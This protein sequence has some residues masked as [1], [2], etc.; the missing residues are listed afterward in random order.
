[1]S[2]V[3]AGVAAIEGSN[4]LLASGLGSITQ[5]YDADLAALAGSGV[6]WHR[7]AHGQQYLGT[8][9]YN[10]NRQRDHCD[11]RRRCGGQPDPVAP[12]GP[13]LHRKDGNGRHLFLTDGD[14][15]PARSDQPQDAATKNYVDVVAQGLDQKPTARLATAAALPTNTYVAGV[16]TI[17]ATGVLTVDGQTVALNDIV[18]VKDEAAALKNGLY[19]CTT[20]GAIGVAA[21][22][23]RHTSMDSSTEF[24]GAFIPVDSEGTTNANSLWLNTNATDPTVGTTAIT[25]VQLNKG[26]DLQAGTGIS[27]SGNVVAIS[28][29]GAAGSGRTHFR[30]RQITLFYR[31]GHRCACGS[32]GGHADVPNHIIERQFGCVD[33][34]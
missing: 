4:I 16:I 21:V 3:S 8:A 7:R 24:R 5:A 29:A 23:T 30:G 11:E 13:D 33:D 19:T 28:D 6:D 22:L 12:R 15:R 17:T 25:F 9:H 2:R 10:R 31:L 27:I 18:L 20:E 34:G 1:M 26:T 32:I 14:H